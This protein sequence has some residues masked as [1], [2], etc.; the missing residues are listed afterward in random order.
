MQ[1]YQ[2]ALT[3]KS[4]N[5]KTGD[6]PVSTTTYDTCPPECPLQKNGCYA[7]NGPLALFWQKVTARKVGMMWDQFTA[8]VAALPA[9]ILWR[10]NQAGDLP[11]ANGVIDNK[12][13]AAL[14]LA[15]QGK[16]GFTYTHYDVLKSAANRK[17]VASANKKGFRINLSANNLS[18]AD[19][20]A[21]L[22]IAPVAVV[23]PSTVQGNVKVT[24]PQGR[25][26]VV[27]PATYRDDVSCK[28]CGLC[29]MS[30]GAIVGFPVH[31]VQSKKADAIASAA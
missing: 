4:R 18:H 30:R 25:K 11:G 27:C 5:A 6:I 7:G 20:L 29:A 8:Q 9:G 2:V 14:V 17:A 10:H 19:K 22:N 31:G 26:V 12:A 16:K 15:N 21:A 3:I 1:A 28:T 23:L 24:T 13:L